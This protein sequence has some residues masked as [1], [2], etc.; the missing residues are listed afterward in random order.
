MDGGI[1]QN[2]AYGTAQTLTYAECGRRG[3]CLTLIHTLTRLAR[4]ILTICTMVGG[5]PEVV[6]VQFVGNC[7]NGD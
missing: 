7:H 2:P 4:C 6:L 1:E 3:G 5:K